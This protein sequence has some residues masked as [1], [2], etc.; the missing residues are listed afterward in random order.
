MII[1]GQFNV[2]S[3]RNKFEQIKLLPQ[4]YIDIFIIS[5]TKIDAYSNKLIPDCG[6]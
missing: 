4:N 3:I 6:I 5:E 1:F 2:N